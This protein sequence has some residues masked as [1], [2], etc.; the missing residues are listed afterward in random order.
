VI[1]ETEPSESRKEI[2]QYRGIEVQTEEENIGSKI[3]VEE[4]RSTIQKRENYIR[5]LEIKIENW[6]PDKRDMIQHIERLSEDNDN[7]QKEIENLKG[8]YEAAIDLLEYKDQ[9]AKRRNQGYTKS[10]SYYQKY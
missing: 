10:Y 8:D 4:Y 2:K 5:Q 9:Q 6:Q 3:D 1:E 7:L